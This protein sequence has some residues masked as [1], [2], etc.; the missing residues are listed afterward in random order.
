VAGAWQ[1]I[2]FCSGGRP[3]VAQRVF[4]L[5]IVELAAAHLRVIG[6]PEELLVRPPVPPLY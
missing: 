3:G 1:A 2:H 4:E 6:S 5:G